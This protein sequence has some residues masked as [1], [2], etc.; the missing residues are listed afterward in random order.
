MSRD[1]GPSK[2]TFS[3]RPWSS[4]DLLRN[5]LVQATHAHADPFGDLLVGEPLGSEL[6]NEREVHFNSRSAEANTTTASLLQACLGSIPDADSFLFGDP[7]EDG[8]QQASHRTARIK[9]GLFVRND[10][11]AS[12]VQ[13]EHGLKGSDHAS[14]QSVERPDEEDLILAS[15]GIA[16]QAVVLGPLF[17]SRDLLG[18]DLPKLKAPAG[19]QGFEVGQ[20]VLGRLILGGH[21]EVDGGLLGR[22]G[23]Q[24][25]TW[26][27]GEG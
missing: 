20:L 12:S 10:L 17:H 26:R 2:M 24:G 15:M 8:D 27:E 6:Q 14:V 7:S 21:S 19:R 5:D 22:G 4:S 1:L 23:H 3:E 18:I 11:N 25:T 16:D 13:L 9:P